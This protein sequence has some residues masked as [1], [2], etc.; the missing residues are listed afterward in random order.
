MYLTCLAFLGL[1]IL[2]ALGLR[3][4][5]AGRV[6]IATRDN[7]RAAD[8]AAVP[9]TNVK[10]SAFLV[11]GV[12]SGIAGGLHVTIVS[13]LNPGTYPPSDSLAV[14]ATAV[15]SEERR[16][17]KECVSTCRSRWSPSH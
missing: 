17:G 15:R 11:A 1:A 12:I 7:Q 10:L 13:S 16:V 9:T 2:A 5:R 6:M 14:F 4:A 3:K 8:A